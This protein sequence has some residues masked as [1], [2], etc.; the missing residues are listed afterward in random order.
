MAATGGSR[1]QNNNS[2]YAPPVP[3]RSL[4][5]CPARMHTALRGSFADGTLRG[6][7]ATRSRMAAQR[8]VIKVSRFRMR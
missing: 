8:H 3:A 2:P 5:W 6:H 1:Q 4:D 7:A